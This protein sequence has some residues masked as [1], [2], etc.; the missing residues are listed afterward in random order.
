MALP[1]V[2]KEWENDSVKV[3]VQNLIAKEAESNKPTAE[4]ADVGE[5]FEVDALIRDEMRRV[6]NGETLNAIDTARFRLEPPKAA[7]GGATSEEWKKALQ[8]ALSQLEHKQN[9]VLNLELMSKF[10]SASWLIHNHLLETTIRKLKEES[11]QQQLILFEI[12]KVR[13][14]E[15]VRPSNT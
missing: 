5:G 8:N 13:K 6:S 10:G 12:N 3:L 2:D 14:T 15:Q 1:Y 11:E 4:V 9:Q 7:K